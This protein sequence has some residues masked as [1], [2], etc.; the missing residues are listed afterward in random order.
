MRSAPATNVQQNVKRLPSHAIRV[1]PVRSVPSPV[2]CF[3]TASQRPV[4]LL[5]KRQEST[6]AIVVHESCGP[7]CVSFDDH[8]DSISFFDEAMHTIT[9]RHRV[10]IK[11]RFVRTSGFGVT[12]RPIH[13]FAVT[14][15]GIPAFSTLSSGKHSCNWMLVSVQKRFSVQRSVVRNGRTI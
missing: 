4:V 11:S 8:D 5:H 14:H 2:P 12:C 7:H 6:V 9:R 3:R 15:L 13:P 1:R 10:D